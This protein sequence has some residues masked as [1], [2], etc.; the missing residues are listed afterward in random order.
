[1]NGAEETVGGTTQGYI[2]QVDGTSRSMAE[3]KTEGATKKP[4]RGAPEGHKR[5]KK[6]GEKAKIEIRRLAKTTNRLIPKVVFNRVVRNMTAE[7]NPFMR[8][9]ATA[10]DAMQEETESY[11]IGIFRGAEKVRSF[12]GRSTLQRED[13]HF[14]KGIMDAE[15]GNGE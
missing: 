11:A 3:A 1:M 2:G 14:S 4:A 15:A 12:K 6:S 9:T 10:L 5:R 13:M 8:W 7:L